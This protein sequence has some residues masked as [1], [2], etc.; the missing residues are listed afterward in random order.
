[1][2]VE[3]WF[4]QLEITDS[5]KRHIRAKEQAEV[6]EQEKIRQEAEKRAWNRELVSEI[7]K[8]TKLKGGGYENGI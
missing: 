8:N 2:N 4:K 6:A 3:R 1:M 5:I 7:S